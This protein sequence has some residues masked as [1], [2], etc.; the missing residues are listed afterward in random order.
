MQVDA[1]SFL[2]RY[3]EGCLNLVFS[4]GNSYSPLHFLFHGRLSGENAVAGRH[5]NRT[6]IPFEGFRC[7]WPAL[8]LVQG[9]G[10]SFSRSPLL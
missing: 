4:Q 7:R 2:A 9:V 1:Q 5:S 10:W 3:Q 6:A 8:I